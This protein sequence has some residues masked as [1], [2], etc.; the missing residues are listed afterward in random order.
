[1]FVLVAPRAPLRHLRNAE[2]SQFS[3]VLSVSRDLRHVAPNDKSKI[4]NVCIGCAVCAICAMQKILSSQMYCLSHET[5]AMLR[6]TINRRLLM[7]VL[8]AP[9]APLRHLCHAENSQLSE[10]LSVS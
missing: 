3:E 9:C 4:V 2:N 6:Q 10:V 1:M 7:F 8:V 5:C